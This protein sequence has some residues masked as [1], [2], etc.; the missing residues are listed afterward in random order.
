MNR[1][2]GLLGRFHPR[3]GDVAERV[4][5][6]SLKSL[7]GPQGYKPADNFILKDSGSLVAD[8]LLRRTR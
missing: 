5:L 6:A 1:T 8:H 4:G 7:L 2:M 3:G